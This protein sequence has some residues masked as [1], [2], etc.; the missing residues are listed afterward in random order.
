MIEGEAHLSRSPDDIGRVAPEIAQRYDGPD[1]IENF[2]RFAHEALGTLVRVK[3][4]K[5]VALD[6]VGEH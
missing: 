4:T 6:R 5:I 2:V 1:G 3:P